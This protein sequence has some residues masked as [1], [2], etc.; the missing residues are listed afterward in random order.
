MVQ[1]KRYEEYKDSGVEWIGEVPAYWN[2]SNLRYLCRIETGSKDT[3]DNTEEGQYPFFVRSQVVERIDEY[4]HDDEAVMTAGDGAGVGKVFHY[5]KGKFASHQRVYIFTK[6]RRCTAKFLFYYL[7]SNL[8]FEVLK[9]NA[10]S[11]VDSLR[12]PMLTGFVVSLPSL[13]EQN[14]ITNFL[15]QRTAEID[16]LITDKE[17]L[18]SL[19]D[20][21]RQAIITEAITK[22]LNP[23]VKMKD[24]GVEWIGTIPEHWEIKKIKHKFTIQKR[25]V[26]QDDP[27]VLSL[28]QRGLKIKDLEDFSGQHAES[29]SNYQL[30]NKNDFVMN[31]MDLLTGFVDC[32]PFIGVT[33]PDYRVFT[34]NNPDECHQYFLYYFQKCYF[35]K[36]FYGHGQGVS[37]FGRWRLQTDVFKE[38]PVMIPPVEEQ[39]EIA[40]TVSSKI[41]DIDEVIQRNIELI[42]KLKEYRQS[43]IFEA[44]TGKI[45][46]RDVAVET[47][48]TA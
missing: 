45:D 33:S 41:N 14:A 24:S 17:K 20:E 12:R 25:I 21:Q 47:T 31:S 43:L 4:T 18:I 26:P 23:N 48:E 38:F 35:E 46:V 9:W 13:S 6:F 5:Y 8:A 44:V 28:T 27:T 16:S 37:K 34:Q 3:Q 1:Y 40:R 10:K 22:G 7:K 42:D 29:Y 39:F 36:I 32:S 30:V 11:T 2:L 15:D 19:L